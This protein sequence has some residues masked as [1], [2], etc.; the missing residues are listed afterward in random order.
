M[1]MVIQNFLMNVLMRAIAYSLRMQGSR[2]KDGCLRSVYIVGLEE[3][4]A[5]IIKSRI[6]IAAFSNKFFKSLLVKS[7]ID[8]GV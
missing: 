3:S 7:N 2:P 8:M 5:F 1:R 6:F 4:N